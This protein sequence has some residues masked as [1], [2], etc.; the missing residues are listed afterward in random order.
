MNGPLLLTIRNMVTIQFKLTICASD[1]IKRKVI[2]QS[3]LGEKQLEAGVEQAA[4][5]IPLK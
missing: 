3:R 1:V 2:R 5:H 4:T